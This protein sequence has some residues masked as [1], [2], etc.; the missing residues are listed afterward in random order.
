MGQRIVELQT[1]YTATED[2][3][4]LHVS[5][6]P[7]N[8]AILSPGPAVIYIVVNGVPSVGQHIMIGSGQ[9]GQQVVKTAVALPAASMPD[10]TSSTSNGNGGGKDG[11][12]NGASRIGGAA[13]VI[14]GGAIALF[15]LLR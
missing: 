14:G 8:A 12:S 7:P 2:G 9:I 3:A 5:Q 10:L 4:T 13:A 1:S 15:A 11:K 6:L